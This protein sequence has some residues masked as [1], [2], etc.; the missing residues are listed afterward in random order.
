MV[1]NPTVFLSL[2][3]LAPHPYPKADDPGSSKYLGLGAVFVFLIL[4]E[5]TVKPELF[6]ARLKE[7]GDQLWGLISGYLSGYVFYNGTRTLI[8]FDKEAT[9]SAIAAVMSRNMSHNI[10][11][12]VLV[13]LSDASNLTIGSYEATAEIALLNQYLKHRMSFIADVSLT[14]TPISGINYLSNDILKRFDNLLLLKEYISGNDNVRSGS[15]R[16]SYCNAVEGLSADTD[17][18]LQI[19]GDTIGSQAIYILLENFI[20]NAV[21]YSEMPARRVPKRGTIDGWKMLY[22]LDIRICISEPAVELRNSYYILDVIDNASKENFASRSKVSGN[23]FYLL[24]RLQGI[25]DE[26]IQSN[27]VL[28]VGGW[29][30]LEMKICAAFL[31]KHPLYDIDFG[32]EFQAG[33]PRL[34]EVHYFTFKD[35]KTLGNR[36]SCRAFW[37]GRS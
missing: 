15:I 3:I 28:R 24:E 8:K 12:H 19:P 11:S 26:A 13:K 29:G 1:K 34:L 20:R 17:V 25:I 18:P 31:R 22:T 36:R 16:L 37:G 21:K 9:K 10:G 33:Q 7:F 32:P 14:Q 27:G 5:R 30:I 35:G 6:Q 23:H 4:D 2:P